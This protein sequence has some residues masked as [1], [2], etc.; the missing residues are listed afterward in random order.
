MIE[1]RQWICGPRFTLADIFLFCFLDFANGV[2]QRLNPE[3]RN[4]M[5]WFERVKARPSTA[6]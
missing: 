4:V 2:G 6:A 3:N 5:A 1:G